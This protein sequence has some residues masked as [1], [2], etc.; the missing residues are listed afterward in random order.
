VWI[1]NHNTLDL[2]MPFGGWKQSG[3]GHELGEEG[4]KSHLSVKAGIRKH[5]PRWGHADGR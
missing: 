5:R 1:N 2:A 3:V 4:L